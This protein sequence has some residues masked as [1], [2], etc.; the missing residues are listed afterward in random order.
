MDKS[1]ECLEFNRHSIRVSMNPVVSLTGTHPPKIR[2]RFVKT[3]LEQLLEPLLYRS[4]VR[5]VTHL[6]W[7]TCLRQ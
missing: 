2:F 4:R 7:I 1:L 3:K 6:I 5:D